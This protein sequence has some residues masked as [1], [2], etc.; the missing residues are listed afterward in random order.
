MKKDLFYLLER[1]RELEDEITA[2][3]RAIHRHPELG[4]QEYQTARLGANLLRENGIHVTTGVGK[5]GVVGT[6]GKGRPA[7]G[8]RADM[9]ALVLQEANKVPYASEVPNVMH[10]CGH[11]A[12][13]AILLG[14]AKLLAQAEDPP[15]GEVRFLFQPSEESVDD[16]GKS[17]AVR[18]VEDGAVDGLDAIIALHV[19][20]DYPL[21]QFEI[22]DGYPTAAVNGYEAEIIGKGCPDAYPHQGL[23]PIFI[24]AQVINSIH[25]IRAIRIDP[26]RP[27][28]ISVSTVRGGDVS[29]VVPTTVNISGTI[30][31]YDEETMEELLKEL[32]RALSV[33]KALGGDYKLKLQRHGYSS[34]NDTELVAILREVI[35]EMVGEN[36][37]LKIDPG[38]AGE[39]FGYMA[40][41]IPGVF[42]HLGAQI[43]GEKRPHRSPVFDLDE[44]V[45]P[46]GVAVLAGTV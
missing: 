45:F 1:A 16:D 44:S 11:D 21:G 38:M 6:L 41:N 36:H 32:E 9:D 23:D 39:D 8:I 13:V 15:E 7:I 30:R 18:M 10:A 3:R 37:L 29:N 42:F 20:S 27:S 22:A 17:G 24:L 34:R 2:W 46:L 4:F 35:V 31:S 12:H 40:R 28:I 19:T 26:V 25:G 33:A 5:T 14:L 43:K